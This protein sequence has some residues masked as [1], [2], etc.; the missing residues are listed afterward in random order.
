[1][2]LKILL[3]LLCVISM[4]AF[5]Q[6]GIK[7]FAYYQDQLPGTVLK[8]LD[9]SGK[10]ISKKESAPVYFIYVTGPASIKVYPMEAWIRG[11]H[12]M[13]TADMVNK[14]PVEI[15]DNL[16]KSIVLVPKLS[17]S[18]QKLNLVQL[19]D[20]KRFPIAKS[21]SLSNEVVV[22]YK[23]KGAF[24]SETVKKLVRLEPKSNE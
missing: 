24:Y 2:K 17:G 23:M 15:R 9:E 22:V 13:A 5:S 14:S 18:V 10:A 21:K 16:G 20:G 3:I 11:K 7:I 8:G 6:T 1:M 4:D 12:Y 19:T